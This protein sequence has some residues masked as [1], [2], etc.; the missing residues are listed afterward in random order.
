[1]NTLRNPL[2]RLFLYLT[3]AFLFFTANVFAFYT[4]IDRNNIKTTLK[5]EQVYTKLV[6]TLLATARDNNATTVTIDGVGQLPLQEEWVNQAAQSAFPANDLEQKGNTI[7]D[8]TFDWLEGKNDSLQFQLDFTQNKQQLG[9]AIGTYAEQRMTSLPRCTGNEGLATEFNAFT[10]PCAPPQAV[11]NPA[12]LKA[13]IAQQ[14]AADQDFLK[15][16][17]VT[18]QTISADPNLGQPST[19]LDQTSSSAT[20]AYSYKTWFLWLLPISTLAFAALGIYLAKDKTKA[21]RRLGFGLIAVSVSLLLMALVIGWGFKA[22]LGEAQSDH[23]M[24]DILTPVLTNLAQEAR[25]TYMIFTLIAL[26]GIIICFTVAKRLSVPR[27][28]QLR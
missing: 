27:V 3:A 6:P 16:P 10:S 12:T 15:D 24:T 1:M 25:N 13:T 23:L 2:S 5:E 7:V 20:P 17:I 19:S 21:L 9:E 8:A 28:K 26:T 14:V 22:A 4:V 11:V 18:P